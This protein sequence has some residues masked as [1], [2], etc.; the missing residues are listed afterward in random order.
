MPPKKVKKEKEETY[1]GPTVA[2][3]ELVFGVAHIYASFNN[4]FIHVSDV[5][6][7]EVIAHVTGG[8][9]GTYL[10]ILKKLIQ[11]LFSQSR[12]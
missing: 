9:K 3:N 8:M 12:S 5:S 4:T 10:Q 7:S 11:Q 2:E 6:G 1:F